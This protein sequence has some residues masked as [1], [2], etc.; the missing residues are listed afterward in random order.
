V[1]VTCVDQLDTAALRVGS[2]V[3]SPASIVPRLGWRRLREAGVAPWEGDPLVRMAKS[4]QAARVWH[5]PWDRNAM[6]WHMGWTTVPGV[7][8]FPMRLA[9][10]GPRCAA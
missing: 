7:T 1:V 2:R 8:A 10:L 4:Y 9:A 5:S 3:G 6:V